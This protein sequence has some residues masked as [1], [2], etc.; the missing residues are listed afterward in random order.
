M[1]IVVNVVGT[2]TCPIAVVISAVGSCGKEGGSSDTAETLFGGGG[3]WRS[4]LL[5]VV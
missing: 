1:T 3:Y 5:D 4:H 2:T